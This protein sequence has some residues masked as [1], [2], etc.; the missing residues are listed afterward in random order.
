MIYISWLLRWLCDVVIHQERN[1]DMNIHTISKENKNIMIELT[2]DDLVTICNA[3]YAQSNEKK[4]ND[5]F[6]QLYSNM[7]VARDLCQYGHIDDFCLHNIV[8][9]RSQFRDVLSDADIATSINK[10]LEDNDFSTALRIYKRIN[11][12]NR[13]KMAEK[14]WN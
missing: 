3:L 1:I 7:M 12:R 6:M 4:H 11:A 2:A 8:K 9:C 10:Y 13:R 5:T 14:V